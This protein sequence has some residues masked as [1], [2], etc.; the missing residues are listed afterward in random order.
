AKLGVNEYVLKS[1]F[2]LKDL[3]ARAI[4]YTG[5]PRKLAAKPQAAP[6]PQ[7]EQTPPTPASPAP[8]PSAERAAEAPPRLLTR[9]Q[10]IARAEKA[11]AAKTL[12]GVVAEVIALAT[13]PRA[14]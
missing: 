13:S 10:C 14:S 9:E 3:V 5:A 11:M 7:P 8:A 2:S 1:S 6:R 4:K 12:S